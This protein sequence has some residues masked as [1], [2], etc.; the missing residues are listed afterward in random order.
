MSSRLRVGVVGVGYL[1]KFHA[2]IYS[3]LPDVE[4]VGVVDANRET[5][6]KIAA[7]YKTTAFARPEDLLGKVDAVS[8]VVPTIYHLEVARPFLENGV[9]ASS[10]P[11][12]S[13]VSPSAPPTWT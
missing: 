9:H 7:E 10:R 2:K 6:D 11:R 4:L 8:V 13:A 3:S 5:A 12:A 1:G